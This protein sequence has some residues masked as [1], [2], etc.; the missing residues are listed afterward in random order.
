MLFCSFFIYFFF[1]LAF[2]PSFH[3]FSSAT[4]NYA[5]ASQVSTVT[6]FTIASCTFSD[7]KGL[8]LLVILTLKSFFQRFISHANIIVSLVSLYYI[9]V[10]VLGGEHEQR[11]YLTQGTLKYSNP[12]GSSYV[13][14]K[15]PTYPPPPPQKP[16]ITRTSHLGQHVGLGEG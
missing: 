15:L 1:L 10:P 14:G 4:L 8:N 7:R 2:E 3:A 5:L 11:S 13:S 9:L 16:T 12:L 6:K